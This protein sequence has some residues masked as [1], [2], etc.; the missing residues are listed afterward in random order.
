MHTSCFLYDL[1]SNVF[2]IKAINLGLLCRCLDHLVENVP[3]IFLYCLSVVSGS[4]DCWPKCIFK[5]HILFHF[6][7]I[8]AQGCSCLYIFLFMDCE[9]V[10]FR[11]REYTIRRTS[12]WTAKL[13]SAGKENIPYRGQGCDCEE[14]GKS[15]SGY[16]GTILAFRCP[17]LLISVFIP[18]DDSE[19]NGRADEEDR[20]SSGQWTSHAVQLWMTTC[21]PLWSVEL[22]YTSRLICLSGTV[23]SA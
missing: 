19:V 12:L 1:P 2:F 14:A 16:F 3:C 5:R 18:H 4:F 11:Q 8:T 22:G 15:C 17:L 21:S 9:A 13:L 6:A 10:Q 7:C 23:A 20:V